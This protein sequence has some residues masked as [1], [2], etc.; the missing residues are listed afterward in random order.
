MIKWACFRSDLWPT[1]GLKSPPKV[2][3]ISIMRKVVA[4]ILFLSKEAIQPSQNDDTFLLSTSI[5][6]RMVCKEPSGLRFKNFIQDYFLK[7]ALKSL[8]KTLWCSEKVWARKLAHFQN[9][10]VTIPTMAGWNVTSKFHQRWRLQN[11]ERSIHYAEGKDG[12][13]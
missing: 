10:S 4:D 5:T 9:F 13:F 7:I 8:R 11:G 6:K 3:N 12:R 1:V 2:I